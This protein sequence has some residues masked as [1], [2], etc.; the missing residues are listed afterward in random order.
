MF[1]ILTTT[2][3]DFST[4][5]PSTFSSPRL[6]GLSK[7]AKAGIGVGV[8]LA[9][10]ALAAILWLVYQFGKR[11]ARPQESHTMYFQ[12]KPELSGDPELVPHT[13]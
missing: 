13:R 8:P 10:V 4:T 6:G 5:T 12:N 3:T 11:R 7:G 1:Q 2:V 9:I